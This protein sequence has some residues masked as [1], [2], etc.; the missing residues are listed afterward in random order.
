MDTKKYY[1]HWFGLNWF[2]L[3]FKSDPTLTNFDEIG[4]EQFDRLF[5]KRNLKFKIL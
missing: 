5:I 2:N 1:L 4:V 3:N